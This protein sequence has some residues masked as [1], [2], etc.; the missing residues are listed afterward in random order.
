[1]YLGL[2]ILELG[3]TVMYEFW[4]DYEKPKYGKNAKF[5]YMDRDMFYYSGKSR[6]YCRRC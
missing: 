5:C 1:M 3:K 2:P 6:R 4:Y